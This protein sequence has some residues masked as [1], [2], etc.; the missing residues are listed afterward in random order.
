MQQLSLVC[1]WENLHAW[2]CYYDSFCFCVFNCFRESLR[3]WNVLCRQRGTEV[4][5]VT[6]FG[7]FRVYSSECWYKALYLFQSHSRAAFLLYIHWSGKAST[8][9]TCSPL[10]ST[11]ALSRS[12]SA[13]QLSAWIFAVLLLI[14]ALRDAAAAVMCTWIK[15]CS[16]RSPPAKRQI[17]FCL[18]I[19]QL[20]C[21][22]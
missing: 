16:S 15:E 9:I 11:K 12:V 17:C 8:W 4:K 18:M 20:L 21:E 1:L 3:R 6:H 5:Q 10:Q 22:Y 19:F 2:G 13:K 7:C 14:T